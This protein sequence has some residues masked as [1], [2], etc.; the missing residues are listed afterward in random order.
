MRNQR[1]ENY[2][3]RLLIQNPNY[4]TIVMDLQTE[5][6]VGMLSTSNA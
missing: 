5:N 3:H 1:T 2:V 6:S 4:T